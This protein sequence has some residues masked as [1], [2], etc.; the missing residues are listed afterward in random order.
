MSCRNSRSSRRWPKGNRNKIVSC[1][2]QTVCGRKSIDGLILVDAKLVVRGVWLPWFSPRRKGMPTVI[3]ARFIRTLPVSSGDS[4]CNGGRGRAGPHRISL[5]GSDCAAG[6]I[7]AFPAAGGS[8]TGQSGL[9]WKGGGQCHV[10]RHDTGRRE[11][12]KREVEL[13]KPRRYIG[14]LYRRSNPTEKTAPGHGR[15]LQAALA[16]LTYPL[17]E[18]SQ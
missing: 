17:K 1:G 6:G 7:A 12:Q 18:A 2:N 11:K 14:K 10:T 3:L 9:C 8:A 16:Y 4:G 5:L 13:E 15:C